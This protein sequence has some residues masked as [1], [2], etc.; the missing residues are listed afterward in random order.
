VNFSVMEMGGIRYCWNKEKWV[1]IIWLFYWLVCSVLG[2]GS[3]LFFRMRAL[4]TELLDCSRREEGGET[5]PVTLR[6]DFPEGA[7]IGMA[8][9]ADFCFLDPFP[10][11]DELSE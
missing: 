5:T 8:V 2:F 1:Q 6:G 4:R 11:E 10:P 3:S 9:R 7:R